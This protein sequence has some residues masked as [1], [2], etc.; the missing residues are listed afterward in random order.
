MDILD[1]FKRV[2][3]S[4]YNQALEK[5][6]RQMRRTSRSSSALPGKEL[7]IEG[8]TLSQW[9]TSWRLIGT[10]ETAE[11]SPLS[12]SI[13]IYRASLDSTTVYIGRAIEISNGGFRKRLRD[14]TRKS[15]SARRTDSGRSMHDHA[16]RLTIAILETQ[17][18]EAAK[19]L[20]RHFIGKY[21]PSWNKRL[22]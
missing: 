3:S 12:N 8:K 19:R 1:I 9:E 20:E 2:G 22:P 5:Q 11:L 7:T 16:N 10:L 17:T 4:F 15:D 14:Y 6:S 13:G 18:V 21:Q